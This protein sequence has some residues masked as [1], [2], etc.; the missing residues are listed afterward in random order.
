VPEKRL[1]ARDR[2]SQEFPWLPIPESGQPAAAAA[3]YTATPAIGPIAPGLSKLALR[4][5]SSAP[6]MCF[7]S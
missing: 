3:Y 2:R 5:H 6:T 1:A 7:C 4:S